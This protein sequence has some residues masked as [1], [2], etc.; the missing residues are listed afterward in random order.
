MEGVNRIMPVN[1]SSYPAPSAATIAAAVAAPSAATIATAVAAAVPTISAINSS[2]S[3]NASPYGGT[4][5]HSYA[6]GNGA[7]T[8]TFTG[9]SSYKY[10][11]I[12][13]AFLVGS[14]SQTQLGITING[15][16]TN[17]YMAVINKSRA[18][19]ATPELVIGINT[20]INLEV[21]RND[22]TQSNGIL[23]I[24]NSNSGAIKQFTMTSSFN[25]TSTDIIQDV[26]G[27]WLNT[28]AISTLTFTLTGGTFVNNQAGAGF[29]LIG[30]N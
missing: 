22:Y 20:K 9:L 6:Q 23:T 28:A 2:V 5:T 24:P 11:K 27:A 16:T 12:V 29:Y 17:K 18:D 19:S 13:W 14:L 10:I 25:N 15:D 30:I 26:S 8:Y 21:I 3:T 1:A 4:V 7:S